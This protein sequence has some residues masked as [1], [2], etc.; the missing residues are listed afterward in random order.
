MP[1]GRLDGGEIT[2][3]QGEHDGNRLQLGYDD[4][5]GCICRMHDVALIDKPDASRAGERRRVVELSL[6]AVYRRLITAG[7]QRS[8][9][10]SATKASSSPNMTA[11]R[12]GAGSA[13]DRC[14]TATGL[15]I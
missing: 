14:E 13:H 4:K 9:D 12:N 11:G 10:R 15:W 7:S 6:R 8:I 2:L 5:A 3:R 1:I